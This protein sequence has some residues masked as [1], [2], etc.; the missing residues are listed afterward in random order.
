[1]RIPAI[2]AGPTTLVPIAYL[3]LRAF[4]A[5]LATVSRLVLR[6]RTFTLLVNTVTLTLGVLALTTIMAVPLAWLAVRSDLRFRGVITALAVIPLAVPGYV[7]AYA[8]LGL[9]GHNGLVTQL[10]DVAMQR[11]RGYWGAT[12]ALSLYTFPYLFLNVRSALMG[13][14]PSL[15]ESA[16]SLGLGGREIVRRVVLPQL[17]PALLAG[18]LVIA[19]YVL[20][21]FG[22]VALMRYEAFSYA[23][24]LQYSAAFDR[25]YAA[26]LSLMLLALTLGIVATEARLLGGQRYARVGGGAQRAVVVTRLGRWAPLAHLYVALVVLASLG[27]PAV[28]LAYWMAQS[29]PDLAAWQ[30]VGTAFVRTASVAI[31]TALL[32]SAVAIPIAYLSARVRM[33]GGRVIER[34]AYLGYAIPPVS[35]ALAMVF[36]SLRSAPWLYQTIPLLVIAYVISFL[37]LAIGPVRSA[38]MQVPVRLEEAAT[39]LGRV[40]FAAFWQVVFP[41]IRR[42]VIA[43]TALVLMVTMKELPITFLLGPTGFTTLAVSVFSRTSEAMM[44]AA[45]PYALA[46]VLFSSL[47]VGLLVSYEGRR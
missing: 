17:R 32:A 16:R 13:L 30:A 37:A 36:F 42:P 7:V 8:L 45:A 31:P 15:E 40:R 22:V 18:W 1:V 39:S 23:I 4:D 27:L 34:L 20:G 2:L 33:R 35:L 12:I 19:L 25:I 5:D 46:I 3:L 10:F 41:V 24:Y 44:A 6:P 38:L 43:A 14:D 47:F 21:D 11:P 29:P 28:V 9:G 26:W